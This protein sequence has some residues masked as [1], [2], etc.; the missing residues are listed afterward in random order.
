MVWGPE[1]AIINLKKALSNARFFLH[2]TILY[3]TH[4]IPERALYY[5]ALRLLLR[6]RLAV[7]AR[8]SALPLLFVAFRQDNVLNE[9][10]AVRFAPPLNFR[11]FRVFCHCFINASFFA[12]C[13]ASYFF[14]SISCFVTLN[15]ATD[16]AAISFTAADAIS[17]IVL[18]LFLL[19]LMLLL[20]LLP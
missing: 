13:L 2:I 1:Y 5:I 7:A 9:V 6:V 14:L 12:F 10:V 20:L 8:Q 18:I 3:Y 11:V 16:T 4:Y 19:L 15:F 17:A